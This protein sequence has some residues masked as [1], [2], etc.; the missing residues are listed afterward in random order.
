VN[1]NPKHFYL[2]SSLALFSLGVCAQQSS[3]S[4]SANS[5]P[6]VAISPSTSLPQMKTADGVSV[7]RATEESTTLADVIPPKPKYIPEVTLPEEARGL[8]DSSF[9]A[10]LGQHVAVAT[11]LVRLTVDED[12]MPRDICV[13]KEAGHGLDRKAFDS[14]ATYR[15]KP[16]TLHG[17]PVP[18]QVIV[19]VGF[20]PF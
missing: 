17:R 19:E 4:G 18:T 3:S 6:H 12:G 11:N 13:V 14:V 10:G 7:C 1:T 8:F 16:A 20:R 15:F 2:C 9:A 5:L